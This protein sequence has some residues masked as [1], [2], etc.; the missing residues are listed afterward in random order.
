MMLHDMACCQPAAI[1]GRTAPTFARD[2]SE[3]CTF[4]VL[5][6]R[7][8]EVRLP[9]DAVVEVDRPVEAGRQAVARTALHM[10]PDDVGV[11]GD[12]TFRALGFRPNPTLWRA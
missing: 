6:A 11:D 7:R 1:H 12:A 5:D 4:A 2:S 3:D 9:D 10:R 8:V